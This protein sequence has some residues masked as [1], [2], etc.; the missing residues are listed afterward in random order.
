M[1]ERAVM[2][3][4]LIKGCLLSALKLL[5]FTHDADSPSPRAKVSEL[6]HSDTHTDTL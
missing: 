2:T 6:T 1:G 3:V 4:M 5:G